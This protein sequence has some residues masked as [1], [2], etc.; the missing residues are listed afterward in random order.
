MDLTKTL[1]TYCRNI[2]KDK[3]LSCQK[4][5][6]ACERFL[7]DMKRQ[8]TEDF[9]Y[10]FKPDKAKRFI[11][12][13]SL[14][15]HTKGILVGKHIN[16]YDSPILLFIFSNIY[17]WYHKD[18]GNRRF[19]K[20]YWQVARKNAKSQMLALVGTYE[21]MAFDEDGVEV[22][23]IYCAATKTEQ[24]KI[25]FDEALFML[26]RCKEVQPY[27]AFTYG[28]IQHIASDSFIRVLS[29]ED[30]KTGDGLNPKCGI[31]DEYHAHD[32]SEI[33]D[34][35]D[36]ATVSRQS[37]LIIIITTAGFN[38]NYPCYTVEY[39]LVS[40][41][42]DPD[43]PVEMDNYF[44]MV[45]E[46]DH[47]ENGE[48]IDDIRDPAVWI[49]ANPIVASYPEGVKKLSERLKEALEAPEKMRDFLTKSVN[50]WV[51]LT[52]LGFISP[53][54]WANCHHKTLPDLKGKSVWI[55]IDFS[56]KIDL[57][58]VGF[59]FKIEVDGVINYVVQ[60]HSFIASETL[61]RKIKTDKVPYDLW[62]KQGWITVQD[63]PIIDYVKAIEFVKEKIKENGWF[64]ECWCLDPW[65]AGQIMSNLVDEGETVVEIRQGAR[66]LSEPTK[67]FRD[68]VLNRQVIHDNN[69]VLSWAISNAIAEKV[70]KNENIQ[71][72]KSKSKGRID[73]IAAIINAHVRC[74]NPISDSC[75]EIIFI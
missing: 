74:M 16:L 72:N 62:A 46:L 9:P 48:L 71:L 53:V 1:K 6:W 27:W 11:N 68:M 60:S 5:K 67:D 52:E 20:V 58:S 25:V 33:Y 43:I 63:G 26:R 75:P 31:I 41:I 50:V 13:C 8:K 10:V 19:N 51:H 39:Q 49:K 45:N 23:E 59:E 15:K 7:R 14:F 32:T 56:S 34:I 28:K 18:T 40:K 69:P 12:W 17:G 61:E 44:V 36:S 70:D 65:C 21:L 55:G 66:T 3:P 64:V 73:P 37:P 35:L 57:T 47:D 29:E 4:H 2:A 38:L 24:A 30:R 22:N 42:L 54:K